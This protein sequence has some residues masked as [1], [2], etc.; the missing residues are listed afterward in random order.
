MG[1]EHVL[2]LAQQPPQSSVSQYVRQRLMTGCGTLN[3]AASCVW[4]TNGV[5][6]HRHL[7][8]AP[9]QQQPQS[10][11]LPGQ[12]QQLLQGHS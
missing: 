11:L 5:R 4:R 8:R 7:E 12:H 6:P 1:H 3:H 2:P 9:A 10:P